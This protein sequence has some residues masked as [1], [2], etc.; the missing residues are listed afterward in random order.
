MTAKWKYGIFLMTSEPLH[1]LY[2]CL[3][4]SHVKWCCSALQGIPLLWYVKKDEDCDEKGSLK[5]TRGPMDYI[6]YGLDPS[7]AYA[8]ADRPRK[9]LGG[10]T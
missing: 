6:A 3:N 5:R 10:D 8:A 9:T 2:S 7:G 4:L 1:Y